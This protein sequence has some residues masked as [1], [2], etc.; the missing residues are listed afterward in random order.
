M[1]TFLCVAA[2]SSLAFVTLGCAEEEVVP[3]AWTAELGAGRFSNAEELARHGD[4]S[5]RAVWGDLRDLA[6]IEEWG[7]D[8][9]CPRVTWE[10]DTVTVEGGCTDAAGREWSGRATRTGTVESRTFALVLDD[11]QVSSA[12]TCD[13]DG[14]A[15]LA[16]DR[17]DGRGRAADDGDGL[18]SFELD[19]RLDH[20]VLEPGTCGT[21]GTST[22]VKRFAGDFAESGGLRPAAGGGDAD[23]DGHAE[24]ARVV[25]NGRGAL[26]DGVDGVTDV[27]S[28]DVVWE[29]GVCSTEP[30]SGETVL[31]A[32]GH[33]AVLSHDGATDCDPT[34]T[35]TWTYDG[36][37]MGE[38]EVPACAVRRPGAPGSA[39][40]P[41]ALLLALGA[42]T[43][44][45]RA[46]ARTRRG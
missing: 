15:T 13:D 1:R 28:I 45:L 46:R 7:D 4:E 37:D 25:W 20:T 33:R 32:A 19:E 17:L 41:L 34:Q 16:V 24:A 9:S 36:R 43:V 44:A 35:V 14:S 6:G 21:A 29:R 26:G 18:V 8:P 10:R 30:L 27:E 42:A 5:A 38:A 40:P 2:A 39:L 3:K 12:S 23:E 31:R 11:V 22:T